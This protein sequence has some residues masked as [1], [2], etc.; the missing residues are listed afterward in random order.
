MVGK[1]I[2]LKKGLCKPPANLPL[3][4]DLR[5]MAR[6]ADKTARFGDLTT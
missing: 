2:L 5:E 1:R 6:N 3:C 4:G